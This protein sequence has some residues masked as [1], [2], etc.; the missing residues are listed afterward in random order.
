MRYSSYDSMD[1]KI[2]KVR[3]IYT[4]INKI[5]KISSTNQ[6]YNQ[7]SALLKRSFLDSGYPV[8]L[9][10]KHFKKAIKS[11]SISLII[12]QNRSLPSEDQFNKICYFGLYFK[13]FRTEL[14][15]ENN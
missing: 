6:F 14:F 10:E 3:L 11:F 5:S 2:Y 7:D 9:V 13:S 1:S 4:M 12:F 8:A 15:C